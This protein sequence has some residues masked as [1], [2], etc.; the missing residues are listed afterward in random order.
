MTPGRYAGRSARPLGRATDKGG[1]S[2]RYRRGGLP[3]RGYG[4]GLVCGRI[5]EQLTGHASLLSPQGR[6]RTGQARR[7]VARQHARRNGVR[8]VRQPGD[9]LGRQSPFALWHPG[10]RQVLR[11]LRYQGGE[12][13]RHGLHA[14]RGRIGRLELRAGRLGGGVQQ[15]GGGGEV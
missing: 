14:H 10:S 7:R 4:Y 8:L 9:G 13:C 6:V 5:R 11:R 15:A 12:R 2:L 1:R 3:W